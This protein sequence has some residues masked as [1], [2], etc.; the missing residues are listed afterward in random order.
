LA[1]LYKGR[2]LTRESIDAHNAEIAETLNDIIKNSSYSDDPDT[3]IV[4][5]P[6]AIK[7]GHSADDYSRLQREGLIC[8]EKYDIDRQTRVFAGGININSQH[9]LFEVYIDPIT[10]EPKVDMTPGFRK[11]FGTGQWGYIGGDIED[12][13]DLIDYVNMVIEENVDL[14]VV[15]DNIHRRDDGKYFIKLYN[16]DTPQEGEI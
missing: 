14:E 1:R 3:G 9:E 12:Q 15:N 4:A 2:D 13:T 7:F 10:G 6:L 16:E 5:A 11:Y 8:F